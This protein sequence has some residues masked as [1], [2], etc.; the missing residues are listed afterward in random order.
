M[1]PGATPPADWDIVYL[2]PKSQVPVTFLPN[3]KKLW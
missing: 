2:S 1:G 3:F